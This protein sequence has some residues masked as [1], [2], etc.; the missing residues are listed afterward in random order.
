MASLHQRPPSSRGA[1]DAGRRGEP[2]FDRSGQEF[3]TA[4]QIGDVCVLF[5]RTRAARAGGATFLRLLQEQGQIMKSKTQNTKRNVPALLV[6]QVAMEVIEG[7][8]VRKF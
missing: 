1:S 5:F 3:A 2:Q 4:V 6:S 7:T 8:S